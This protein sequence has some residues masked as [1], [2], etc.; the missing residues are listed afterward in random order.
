MAEGRGGRG[1]EHLFRGEHTLLDEVALLERRRQGGDRLCVRF[2]NFV[3]Q[4]RE[5]RHCDDVEWNE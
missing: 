1:V 2:V 5:E 3:L 4:G